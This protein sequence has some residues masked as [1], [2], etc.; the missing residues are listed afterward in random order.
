V[1]VVV[2]VDVCEEWDGEGEGVGEEFAG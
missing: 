1:D 2:D